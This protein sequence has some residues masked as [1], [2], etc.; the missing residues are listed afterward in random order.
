MPLPDTIQAF[1]DQCLARNLFPLAIARGSKAPIGAG[2]ST[3]TAPI[4]H[5]GAAGVGLR[6]GD[7]GL[8]AFDVDVSNPETA[9]KLLQAFKSV[10][11]VHI[12]VRWGRKPRFLIP[13]YLTDAPVTGRTFTFA[14][15][16]EKLQ[17]MGGQF[18]AFGPHAVTGQPYEWEN[19]D[20]DFPRL[21]A[22]QL[23]RILSDVPL[24]AGTSL[25][26]S[27][28]HETA[29]ADELAEAVPR[30]QDEWQAGRDAAQRYLGLLKQ[31]LLG[32]TEGRGSTIF[33][34]VGVLKFAEQNG[35]CTREE[36]EEAIT[37]AGHSLDEGIGGRT[38]GE[39]ISRQDTLPV[40]RGNLVMGAVMSRRTMLQGLHDAINMPALGARTGFEIDLEG[41]EDELPWLLYQRI[42]CGE[43]HF[44][45]GHSGAGKSTVVSDMAIHYLTGRS[46]LDADIER[47]SGHVLWVAAEDDYGTERRVRHLLRA[48][49]NAR[50]LAARFHLI[51]GMPN[52][53]AFEQQCIAQVDAMA[54][55]GMRVDLLVLDTWGASGMCFADNDTEAVLKAMFVLKNVAR[56]T[57]AAAIVT[58]H[59]P[60]GNEDAWQ[61]G[62]GA[63][64]GNSGFMYRVTAGKNDQISIDC[65][66][67]RGA[68]KAKS[69]TGVLVSERYGKDSKGRDT[70]V[71]VFKREIIVTKEQQEQSAVL[72]LAAML[73][74]A[75]IGGMD[76]LRSGHI[77]PFD[78]VAA[79]VGQ[80]LRNGEVPSFV[81]NLDAAQKIFDGGAFQ[82]LKNSGHIR[83]LRGSPFL[84]IYPPGG[85]V[86]QE[87]VIPWAVVPPTTKLNGYPWEQT[88]T[89]NGTAFAPAETPSWTV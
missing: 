52:P 16:G 34:L 19:W 59:L 75:T 66:K 53:L 71:N 58:D 80:G 17:L 20:S 74:G 42:L 22:E 43:V 76:A 38:L 83:T 79:D 73:P 46:W 15:D 45:T 24:R 77:V 81:V 88:Q 9:A 31:E 82:T 87:L 18:V 60:L 12:P 64:A 13:F 1:W 26:F 56:R 41:K 4:A 39:E 85:S 50:E 14:V 40:L 10:L 3:W 2:W 44:F 47:T 30:T 5:P 57:G 70:T 33:A 48:E 89:V 11:G 35:M 25:R 78:S 29:S 28:D 32:R 84:A 37:G 6:C 65:G 68:P 69:Y 55:M 86:R 8:S 62:N 49:P 54:A 36:I 51:R 23:Q 27:A 67:A 7:G 61:K 72:R 21:T 63:K